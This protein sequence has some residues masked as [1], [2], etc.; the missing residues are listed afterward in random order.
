MS[1]IEKDLIRRALERT[2][3]N[4]NKAAEVLRIKRTTLVEKMK[5]LGLE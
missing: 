1:S 2:R 3:G 5:R 4:R